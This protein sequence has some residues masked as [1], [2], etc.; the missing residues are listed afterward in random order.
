MLK[1]AL[2]DVRVLDLTQFEAGTTCTMMLAF[3][4]AEVIKVESPVGGEGGRL[5]FSEKR[6]EGIDSY[7]FI[8]LNPNKKSVTLNLRK[9][10]GIAIF[11]EMVKKAD[12]VVNNFSHGTMEKLGIGYEVIGKI[13]P[14]VIYAHVTGYGSYGPYHTYPCFDITAQAMGG[15]MSITGFP[16]NPPTRCGPG[17]GDSIAAYNLA[18]GICAALYYREKTGEGQEVEVAMQDS[19]VNTLR[20]LYNFYYAQGA[21][22]QRCGNSVRGLA[23]WNTY[24]T[25]DGW[26][27]IGVL[28]DA[29]WE[30]LLRAIGKEE[31]IGDPRFSSPLK[32]GENVQVVDPLIE[33]WTSG[34]TK[35]EAM[36]YLVKRDVPCGAVLDAQEILD[37]PHLNERGMIVEIDHPTR[38]RLK[39]LGSP[40]KLSKSPSRMQCSPLLGQDNEVVYRELMGYTAE[41]LARLRAEKVI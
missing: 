19:L 28:T 22:P 30:N 35:R 38:G 5:S 18:T 34:R 25:K 9:E 37:D 39:T 36:E 26:V 17:L 24:R 8:M 14:R 2:G 3:L 23:P 15:I 16:E 11:Q 7:Y 41:D 10:K 29:L 31:Y 4:G 13:N 40:I 1:G 27:A 6:N 20:P 32:R 33:E 21:L 12:V